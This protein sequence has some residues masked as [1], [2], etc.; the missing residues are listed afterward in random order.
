M[1]RG[2]RGEP[3]RVVP[4]TERVGISWYCLKSR[5]RNCLSCWLA[6]SIYFYFYKPF[7]LTNFYSLGLVR[8]YLGEKPK[9]V[10]RRQCLWVW[11]PGAAQAPPASSSEQPRGKLWSSYLPLSHLTFPLPY[12]FFSHYT[13]SLTE[14]IY[15]TNP[16]SVLVTENTPNSVSQGPC[17]LPPTTQTKHS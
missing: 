2:A 9:R 6:N 4:G 11:E 8:G 14:H 13:A 17:Y 12:T 3:C 7:I 5:K 16:P 15:E 1:Q 10:G